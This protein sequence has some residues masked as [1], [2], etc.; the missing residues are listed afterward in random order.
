MRRW[1]LVPLAC[2]LLAAACAGNGA[3]RAAPST[4]P[5]PAAD[6]VPIARALDR[7][8]VIDAAVRDWARATNVVEAKAAAERAR[9]LITG[10]GVMGAGDLDGDG[11]AGDLP[12]EGLLPGA[13]AAPGLAIALPADCVEADVLGGGW[14]TPA[15]RWAT[16]ESAIA[17]WRPDNNTFPSLPSHPQRV[18]GWATLTLATDDLDDARE[19]AGHA[20][21][22][23]DVTRAAIEGC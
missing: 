22:H 16:L 12:D 14:S 13:A 9:N 15:S 8:D 7:L 1:P 19:F 6:L 21:I 17:A 20:L 23:V 4:D 11:V 10:P 2:A 5:A 18:V 3:S